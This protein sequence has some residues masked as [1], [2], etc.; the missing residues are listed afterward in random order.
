M[1]LD[2]VSNIYIEIC[3]VKADY[4]PFSFPSLWV[5]GQPNNPGNGTNCLAQCQAFSGCESSVYL[6]NKQ[7]IMYSVPAYY[8]LGATNPSLNI[9]FYDRTC[10]I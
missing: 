5:V 1:N 3:G 4:S 7:C 2:L 6:K 8:I 10:S 9:L